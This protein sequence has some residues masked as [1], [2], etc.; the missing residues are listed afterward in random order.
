[1]SSSVCDVFLLC[2]F[3]L[4]VSVFVFSLPSVAD[5]V[6]FTTMRER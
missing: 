5:L 4:S 1:M 2:A 6:F 3:L